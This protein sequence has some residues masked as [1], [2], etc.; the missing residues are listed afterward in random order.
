MVLYQY[1]VEMILAGGDPGRFVLV[2]E[3]ETAKVKREALIQSWRELEPGINEGGLTL[4][5]QQATWLNDLLTSY[6]RI[7][8]AAEGDAREEVV[9]ML[10]YTIASGGR[11][12]FLR[13][14]YTLRAFFE[15]IEQPF[16]HIDPERIE[17]A[18]E[19]LRG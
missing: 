7:L 19:H 13:R 8:R 12:G 6:G 2:D 10:P 5:A 3:D 18:A 1:F 15:Q 17:M 14:Y 16:P 9:H 4:S 11:R